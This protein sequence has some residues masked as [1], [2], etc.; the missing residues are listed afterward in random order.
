MPVCPCTIYVALGRSYFRY[1]VNYATLLFVGVPFFL[2]GTSLAVLCLMLSKLDKFHPFVM[3]Q[4]IYFI[5]N[6]CVRNT[7]KLM[8]PFTHHNNSAGLSRNR[9]LTPDT[10][11]FFSS[12]QGL[13]RLWYPPSILSINTGGCVSEAKMDRTWNLPLTYV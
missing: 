11:R 9:R 4:F 8:R 3:F 6:L 13:G 12:A 1:A 7:L 2:Y 5:I 10:D